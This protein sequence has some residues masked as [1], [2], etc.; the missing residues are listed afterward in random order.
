MLKSMVGK[1][2]FLLFSIKTF[3]IQIFFFPFVIIEFIKKNHHIQCSMEH[4]FCWSGKG[5]T[6]C[7]ILLF[8]VQHCLFITRM[9]AVFS[10]LKRQKLY[11]SDQRLPPSHCERIQQVKI[12]KIIIIISFTEIYGQ[13]HIHSCKHTESESLIK[14]Y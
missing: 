7:F 9:T 10:Y 13:A 8:W 1:P 11:F 14:K 2:L 6:W 3:R 4:L 5:I 12:E